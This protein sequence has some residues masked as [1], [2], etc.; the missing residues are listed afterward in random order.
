MARFCTLCSSSCG[1]STYIGYGSGG[2]LIDAGTNAKQLT[3]ALEHFSTE[4][5][6]IKAIFVTHEHT[7]HIGALRVF[8]SRFNIPVYGTGGTL[9]ALEKGGH[10]NGNFKTEVIGKNGIEAAGMFVKSFAT[11]HDSAES[12]GYTVTMPNETRIS[13]VTDTGVI[14]QDIVDN[15]TGSEIVLLESNHDRQMLL[16]GPYPFSLQQRVLSEK[17][18]LSNDACAQIACHFVKTGTTRLVLGHL[19]KENNT[20]ATAFA[21]TSLALGEMGAVQGIDYMLSVAPS[22]CGDEMVRF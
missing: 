3:L 5:S 10:L 9:C 15:V 1:N 14:T 16:N 2:I 19:S 4:P 8:A 12:C 7:D 18:H 20:A 13:V 17:G 11:S 6:T 22:G 21:Q